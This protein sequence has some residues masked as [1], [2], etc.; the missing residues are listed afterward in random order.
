MMELLEIYVL[1]K[2]F[3]KFGERVASEKRLKLYLCSGLRLNRDVAENILHK[4]KKE[5]FLIKQELGEFRFRDNI[6]KIYEKEINKEN[7]IR[8][9]EK[10][11]KRI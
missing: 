1:N 7:L 9:K 11:R 10:F 8:K 5:G 2:L 4:F 3:E 6:K